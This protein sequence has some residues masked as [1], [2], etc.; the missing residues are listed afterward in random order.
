MSGCMSKKD[1][2]ASIVSARNPDV[3]T[4]NET[5]LEIGKEIW[6][7]TFNFVRIDKKVKKEEVLQP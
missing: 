5:C 3:V 7:N 2:I 1:S 4:L 6:I